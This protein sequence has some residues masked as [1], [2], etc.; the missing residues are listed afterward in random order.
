MQSRFSTA[1]RVCRI[2]GDRSYTSYAFR[3]HIWSMGARP[4]IPPLRHEAPVAYPEWIYT[5]CQQVEQ[6]RAKLNEWRAVAT[7]YEK[8]AISFTS[9]LCLAATLDWKKR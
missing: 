2:G 8:T 6:L 7:R 1:C 3:E 5:N 4:A 9:G